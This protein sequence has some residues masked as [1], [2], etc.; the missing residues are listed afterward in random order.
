MALVSANSAPTWK[1]PAPGLVTIS[2]P[3]KPTE[4]ALQRA[5]P[6]FSLNSRIEAKVANSGDEKLI[7]IAPAS[8]IMLKAMIRHDCEQNC[9]NERSTWWRSRVVRKTASPVAGRMSSDSVTSETSERVKRTSPNGY[10]LTSHFEHALETENTSVAPTMYKIPRGTCS[11]RLAAS[12]ASTSLVVAAVTPCKSLCT[13]LGLA[14]IGPAAQALWHGKALPRHSL[15]ACRLG[16]LRR[17]RGNLSCPGLEL[18]PFQTPRL[19]RSRLRAGTSVCWLT[20]FLAWIARRPAA[21]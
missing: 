8:D 2:T 4:S 19:V 10:V 1:A 20:A 11:R 15:P 3:R 7:A 21:A 12:V 14:A 9:E 16:I 5:R 13:V 18:G 17:P 6:T